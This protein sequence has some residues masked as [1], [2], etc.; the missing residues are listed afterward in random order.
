MI[1]L[2]AP[3]KKFKL[4]AFFRFAILLLRFETTTNFE[5]HHPVPISTFGPEKSFRVYGGDVVAKQ[6]HAPSREEARS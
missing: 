2:A 4:W 3:A 6:R 1:R 5:K